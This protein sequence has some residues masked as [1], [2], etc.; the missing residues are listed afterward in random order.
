MAHIKYNNTNL[1]VQKLVQ[2][3]GC[4][5]QG[6]PQRVGY[7]RCYAQ[8]EK[9][10]DTKRSIL[11]RQL[12]PGCFKKGMQFKEAI[13]LRTDSKHTQLMRPCSRLICMAHCMTADSPPMK[14]YE[15]MASLAF[16]FSTLYS[17]PYS[18]TTKLLAYVAGH[19]SA[20]ISDVRQRS[21]LLG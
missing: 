2:V 7:D 6:W 16:L 14:L 12:A 18:R 4:A 5:I 15:W 21:S 17:G 3:Y 10:F 9:R 20:A 11:Q 8:T 19:G 13:I 1:F